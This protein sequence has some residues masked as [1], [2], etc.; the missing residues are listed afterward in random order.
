M[1]ETNTSSIGHRMQNHYE[2]ILNAGTKLEHFKIFGVDQA[3]TTNV[4]SMGGG[5]RGN[6]LIN[7]NMTRKL[8]GCCLPATWRRR[9]HA[10][11]LWES[12]MK[13]KDD[14]VGHISL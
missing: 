9:K 6:L 2:I 5:L 4:T 10:F 7:K 14:L 13:L 12:H 8:G 1:V 3:T 11:R